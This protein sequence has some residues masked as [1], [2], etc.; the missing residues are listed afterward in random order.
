[1][2]SVEESLYREGT[3]TIRKFSKRIGVSRE[4]AKV[5]SN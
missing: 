3:R 5:L 4:T 1:M 2:I